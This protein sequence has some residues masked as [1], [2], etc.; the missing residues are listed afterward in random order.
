[1]K[2]DF[3][4]SW[5]NVVDSWAELHK[6]VKNKVMLITRITCKWFK[7]QFFHFAQ[8]YL[9]FFSVRKSSFNVVIAT[10]IFIFTY[11]WFVIYIYNL[12]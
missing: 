12:V 4:G 2:V 9:I 10:S 7:C 3:D 1:M 8:N 5:M 6:K 11:I